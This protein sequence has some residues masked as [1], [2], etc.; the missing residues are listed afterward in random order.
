MLVTD[1]RFFVSSE[2]SASFLPAFV[3]QRAALRNILRV[4]VL[5]ASTKSH[6]SRSFLRY[7]SLALIRG[8]ADPLVEAHDL[9][10]GFGDPPFLKRWS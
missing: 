4:F 5:P 10:R 9:F 1:P 3:P 2:W 7:T 8:F 6:P